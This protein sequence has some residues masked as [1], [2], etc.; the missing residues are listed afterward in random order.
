MIMH[1]K[2]T[3]TVD[4]SSIEIIVPDSSGGT[5]SPPDLSTAP[6]SFE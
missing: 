2:G 4:P 3:T 5:L 1:Y 6:P